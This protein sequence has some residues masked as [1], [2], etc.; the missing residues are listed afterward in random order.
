MLTG[1]ICPVYFFPLH[2]KIDFTS[3][4]FCIEHNSVT[5]SLVFMGFYFQ[6]HANLRIMSL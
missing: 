5:G 6:V 2:A 4:D 1:M 3:H